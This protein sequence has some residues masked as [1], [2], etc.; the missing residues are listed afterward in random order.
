MRE[1][2]EK[3]IENIW[4]YVIVACVVGIPFLLWLFFDNILFWIRSWILWGLILII[5]AIILSPSERWFVFLLP[6]ACVALWLFAYIF[7][8]I[9][10]FIWDL[11][12]NWNMI[13][14]N[15]QYGTYEKIYHVPWCSHYEDTDIEP[16][17][18]EKWFSSESEAEAAW[19]RKCY[20]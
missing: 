20:D 8:F 16:M 12:R 2:R 9:W 19:W 5:W 3:Q 15:I 10:S 1:D 6:F 14:G 4:W 11:Y 18:W 7:S 17:D 13:K